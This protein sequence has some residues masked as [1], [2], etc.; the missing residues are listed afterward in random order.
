MA[1]ATRE[2]AVTLPAA[3]LL[4]ELCRNERPDWRE[5]VRRQWPHWALLLAGG[6]FLLF[7]QRYFDLVAYGYG[8]RSLAD[9]LITQVGGVSYLVLRLVSLHGYNIDPALP[10]LTEWTPALRFQAAMFLVLF[11]LGH[12]Q[13]APPPLDRVR[14]PVVLP[15]ARAD[16]LDRAAPGRG[17]RPPALS[18]LAGVCFSPFV[19][20]C[21]I[22]RGS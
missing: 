13:P 4:C 18:R 5:I 2:T 9:N 12:R 7:N 17:E 8:E 19:F 6:V 1:V 15:A 22:F 16:Q 14:H 10:T 3:L 20:S 11:V 21:A